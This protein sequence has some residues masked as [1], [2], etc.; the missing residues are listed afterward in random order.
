MGLS[1]NVQ[2]C[3]GCKTLFLYPGFGAKLCPECRKK[4]EEMFAKVKKYLD[5]NGP[6]NLYSIAEATGIPEETIKQWL[7]DGRLEVPEDSDV[8]IKCE[9]CGCDIRS[10][11]YCPACAAELTKELKGVYSGAVGELPK[12]QSGKMRFLDKN[13][14]HK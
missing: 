1:S 3:L 7:K 13:K 2:A 12:N 11:R 9:R 8:Y 6:A 14:L 10:G 5:E 4:E